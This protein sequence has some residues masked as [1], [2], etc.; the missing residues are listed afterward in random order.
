MTDREFIQELREDAKYYGDLGYK[1]T[2]LRFFNIANRMEA[3]L[4]D[5]TQQKAFISFYTDDGIYIY[6]DVGN[7]VGQF[8]DDSSQEKVK[9]GKLVD[10]VRCKNCKFYEKDVECYGI[11]KRDICRLSTGKCEK[12][13]FVP[14]AKGENG[15]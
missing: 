11:G 4:S 7:L 8:I 3:L 10:A 6:D 12:M 1:G 14:M 5:F 9:N 2:S 13:I 15:C